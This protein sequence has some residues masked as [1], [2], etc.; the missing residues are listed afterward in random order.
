MADMYPVGDGQSDSGCELSRACEKVQ[1]A[2]RSGTFAGF[3]SRTA[4]LS[5][6]Q[7]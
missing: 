4:A 3:P 5:T 7:V 2:P 1:R 6:V